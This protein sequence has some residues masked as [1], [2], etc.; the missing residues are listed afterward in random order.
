M[1]KDLMNLTEW[2]IFAGATFESVEEVGGSIMNTNRCRYSKADC[3]WRSA[4]RVKTFLFSWL[5]PILVGR[6]TGEV[7][8]PWRKEKDTRMEH[9]AFK[10]LLCGTVSDQLKDEVWFKSGVPVG[11]QWSTKKQTELRF[12]CACS[13]AFVE[14]NFSEAGILPERLSITCPN[15]HCEDIWEF[16]WWIID[17]FNP[18][19][20]WGR[21]TATPVR[22]YLPKTDR[23]QL[24]FDNS[25]CIQGWVSH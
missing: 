3:E 17:G 2:R 16:D 19:V 24:F 4:T 23:R 6:E 9:K 15:Q 8:C 20:R 12:C 14:S 11:R 13:P 21:R 10:T 5:Q 25:S 18:V 7:Q 1:M 22:I